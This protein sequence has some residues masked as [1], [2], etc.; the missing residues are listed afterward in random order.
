MQPFYIR[1][2]DKLPFLLGPP[3]TP[4]IHNGNFPA[5]FIGY[6]SG[7]TI[8]GITPPTAGTYTLTVNVPSSTIGQNTATFSQTAT[9][10]TTTGLPP[11]VTP[12]TISAVPGATDANGTTVGCP[13]RPPGAVA[14]A[15][16]R[17]R[18]RRASPIGCCTWST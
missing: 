15:S 5:G 14:S 8:F 17:R 7:F 10:T 1:T 11:E 12:P 9:L 3:V 18:R 16:R 13:G 6:D 4:D 2:P